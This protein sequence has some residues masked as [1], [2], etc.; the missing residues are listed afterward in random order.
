M[1]LIKYL[2]PPGNT[3][4]IWYASASDNP[5]EYIP[6]ITEQINGEQTLLITVVFVSCNMYVVRLE[7][8][9]SKATALLYKTGFQQTSRLGV[10]CRQ[11]GC[12]IAKDK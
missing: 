1:S 7:F 8:A 12:R 5:S 2:L 11:V 10:C 9:L 3:E 6:W 4:P